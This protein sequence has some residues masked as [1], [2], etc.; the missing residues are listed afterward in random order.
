MA[1][2][3]IEITN[4]KNQTVTAYLNDEELGKVEQKMEIGLTAQTNTLY[5]KYGNKNK[6][7]NTLKLKN[8]GNEQLYIKVDSIFQIERMLAPLIPM[9]FSAFCFHKAAG[10]GYYA[11]AVMFILFAVIMYLNRDNLM[12]KK[13]KDA[14]TL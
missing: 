12:L 13:L 10:V 8:T 6:K 11:F 7:S 5:I 4:S 9:V 14:K 1:K 3:I 2:V